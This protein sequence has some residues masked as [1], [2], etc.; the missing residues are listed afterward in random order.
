MVLDVPLFRV[1]EMQETINAEEMARAE[2]FRFEKDRYRFIVARGLLR[3]ILGYYL[4]V[5][6][7]EL[8][9]IYGPHGKPRL[10]EETG[11][12]WLRFNLTHSHGRGLCAVTAHREV[13]IDIERVVSDIENDLIAEHFFSSGENAALH[14]LPLERRPE[15]FYRCWTLREAYVK[16]IGNGLYFSLDQFEVVFAHGRKPT[17]R[18]NESFSDEMARWSLYELYPWPGY[19]AALTVEGHGVRIKC[20]ER[21]AD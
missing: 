4:G 7:G 20:W 15:M 12:S 18:S 5:L 14:K 9:F 21:S 6:P 16:A 3:A 19:A 1:E 8:Q 13:G 17:L 11:G 2:G 10:A